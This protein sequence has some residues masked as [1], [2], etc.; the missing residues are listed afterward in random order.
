MKWTE[1]PFLI[2]SFLTYHPSVKTSH[3]C[4]ELNN[5]DLVPCNNSTL[6]DLKSRPVFNLYPQGEQAC[7]SAFIPTKSGP[8]KKAE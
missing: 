8:G 5:F 7:F 1:D 3:K 6:I 2:L 4:P